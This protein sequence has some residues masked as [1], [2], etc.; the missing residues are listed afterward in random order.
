MDCSKLIFTDID[1]ILEAID[2]IRQPSEAKN[3]E[4]E[5]IRA[6]YGSIYHLTVNVD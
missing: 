5:I 1:G 6:G 2:K 4:E 3:H